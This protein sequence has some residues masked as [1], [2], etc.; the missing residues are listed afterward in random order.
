MERLIEVAKRLTVLKT[1][2]KVPEYRRFLYSEIKEN[3]S[4]L[5]GIYGGRGVGKTTLIVQLLKEL[6]LPPLKSSLYILRPSYIFRILV[7]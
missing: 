1:S 2:Q 7:I 3:T 6:N 5:V 4:K